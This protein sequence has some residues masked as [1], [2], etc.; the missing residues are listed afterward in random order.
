MKRSTIS[1]IKRYVTR[2]SEYIFTI[3]GGN[4]IFSIPKLVYSENKTINILKYRQKA[5]ATQQSSF[6]L[7]FKE[8]ID[9]L[10]I[11]Y[12]QEFPIII[13]EHEIWKDY[14]NYFGS[15]RETIY[16]SL[17]YYFPDI[18]LA[19]EIDSSYHDNRKNYDKARDK[20]LECVCGIYT[21]RFYEYGKNQ[22]SRKISLDS[23]KKE[24]GLL[25]NYRKSWG[26][27]PPL[28]PDYSDILLDNFV[29]D[30]KFEIEILEK[31]MDLSISFRNSIG[32]DIIIPTEKDL[33]NYGITIPKDKRDFLCIETKHKYYRILR[34]D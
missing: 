14:L 20:Y 12:I 26:L 32:M 34:K 8:D 15:T 16:F 25:S 30:N 10:G 5:L 1:M 21:L 18:G 4:M 6:S 17:D 7:S 9:K 3:T 23:L 22:K 33:S 29:R 13:T 31:L 11:N 28:G 19:V 2:S 24:I 27:C